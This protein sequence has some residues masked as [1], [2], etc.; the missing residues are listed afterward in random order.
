MTQPM[1]VASATARMPI[2]SIHSQ[3]STTRSVMWLAAPINGIVTRPSPS[4]YP[5]NVLPVKQKI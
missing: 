5:A 3:E 4:K 1:P 2:L